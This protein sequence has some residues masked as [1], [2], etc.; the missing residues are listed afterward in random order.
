MIKVIASP[1][2]QMSNTRAIVL[3]FLMPKDIL[4]RS[5]LA[6]SNLQSILEFRADLRTLT[7]RVQSHTAKQLNGRLTKL[8]TQNF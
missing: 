4:E 7:A 8:K 5:G 2:N 3:K 1:K 6:N